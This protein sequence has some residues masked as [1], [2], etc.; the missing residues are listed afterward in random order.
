MTVSDFFRRVQG[1]PQFCLDFKIHSLFFLS[2]IIDYL[3]NC[4]TYTVFETR[5]INPPCIMIITVLVVY[6]CRVTVNWVLYIRYSIVCVIFVAG[7][8]NALKSVVRRLIE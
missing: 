7:P 3:H 2:S 6:A 1:D 5:V 4:Q 8:N